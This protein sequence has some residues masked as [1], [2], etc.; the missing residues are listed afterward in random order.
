MTRMITLMY[1][2]SCNWTL[3]SLLDL[4]APWCVFLCL[5]VDGVYGSFWMEI[6]DYECC[7]EA[8]I[9]LRG[10]ECCSSWVER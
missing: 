9:Q 1:S 3:V 7:P 10:I 5:F 8:V 6:Y 4:V 2:T